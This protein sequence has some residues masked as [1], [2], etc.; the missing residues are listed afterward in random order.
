MWK[1]MNRSAHR[2]FAVL[3]YFV[4]EVFA[5]CFLVCQ[6]GG[7]TRER[8]MT[9]IVDFSGWFLCMERDR[10]WRG[11]LWSFCSWDFYMCVGCWKN[12][13][14]GRKTRGVFWL[15]SVCWEIDNGIEEKDDRCFLVMFLCVLFVYLAWVFIK[16][17]EE[18]LK[19]ICMGLCGWPKGR[20]R[21]EKEWTINGNNELV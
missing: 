20:K 11:F 15:V 16:A 7:V 12:G 6:C 13:G 4:F 21:R 17:D 10:E 3:G 8:R 5:V 14:D 18:L 19:E 9:E 1:V 2:V